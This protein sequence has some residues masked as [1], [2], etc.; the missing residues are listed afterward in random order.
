[1][2]KG[3]RETYQL[4]IFESVLMDCFRR[5]DR[6]TQMRIAGK[7]VDLD[8]ESTRRKHIQEMKPATV[9][10]FEDYQKARE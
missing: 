7:V 3:E 5:L 10:N 6:D 2:N 8:R 4:N 9:V 1:M